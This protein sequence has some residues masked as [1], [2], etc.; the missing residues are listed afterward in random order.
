[1]IGVKESFFGGCGSLYHNYFLLGTT[2]LV[3]SVSCVAE[4]E[5]LRVYLGS[6]FKD[7]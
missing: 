2:F 5:V 1:V 6:W 4:E 3:R 7:D